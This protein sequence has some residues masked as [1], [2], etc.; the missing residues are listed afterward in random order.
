M[1]NNIRCEVLNASFEPLS[2]VSGRRALVLVL[3]GRAT[4]LVEHPTYSVGSEKNRY[5]LPTQILLNTMVKVGPHKPV[6]L[7][8]RNL[9]TRDFFICQYCF[10]HRL[11]LKE[12]ERLTRDHIIPQSLGGQDIWTNVVTAC[13]RC[14][15]KKANKRL[16]DC[17]MTLKTKPRTPSRIEIWSA[18]GAKMSHME[19]HQTLDK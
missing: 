19:M 5:A 4:V 3:K 14:N 8:Q 1:N 6:Q 2:I 17:G 7:T 12:G 9:F 15:H 10:R 11:E 18:R 13:N 16:S